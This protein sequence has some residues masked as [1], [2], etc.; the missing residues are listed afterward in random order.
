MRFKGWRIARV[1]FEIFVKWRL[2]SWNYIFF[3][4]ERWIAVDINFVVHVVKDGK[5]GFEGHW[6]GDDDHEGKYEVKSNQ[7]VRT[8][9]NQNTSHNDIPENHFSRMNH[10]HYFPVALNLFFLTSSTRLHPPRKVVHPT[11]GINVQHNQISWIVEH[12]GN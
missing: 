8:P 11:Q 10:L 6:E 5:D 4:F 1:W 2:N 7:I 12:E 9:V 3:R